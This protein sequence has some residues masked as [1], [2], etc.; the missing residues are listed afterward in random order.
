MTD[1][2]IYIQILFFLLRAMT[3]NINNTLSKIY[4]ALTPHSHLPKEKTFIFRFWVTFW[5]SERPVPDY[6]LLSPVHDLK[7][8]FLSYHCTLMYEDWYFNDVWRIIYDRKLR[9]SHKACFNVCLTICYKK[10]SPQVYNW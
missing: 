6:I 9:W 8:K 4:T 1:I 3:S 5:T 7:I 2:K 10:S